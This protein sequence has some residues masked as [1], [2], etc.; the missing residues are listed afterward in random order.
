[1][2]NSKQFAEKCG[3]EPRT[4]RRWILNGDIAPLYRTGGGHAYF[5]EDHLAAI[6]DHPKLSKM[7]G[8]QRASETIL[9]P[10]TVSGEKYAEYLD[11]VRTLDFSSLREYLLE[12]L[13]IPSTLQQ[14][15]VLAKERTVEALPTERTFV[16]VTFDGQEV[17][18]EVTAE[19]EPAPRVP[20]VAEWEQLP[21][22][23]NS[24]TLTEA[25]SGMTGE[26]V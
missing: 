25:M 13:P 17:S 6:L 10:I 7:Y 8:G 9:L 20:T 22:L 3:V 23:P 14:A 2:M 1:M 26:V 15:V 16:T 18:A 4:L 5:T 12:M 11:A 24:E 19:D 21:G